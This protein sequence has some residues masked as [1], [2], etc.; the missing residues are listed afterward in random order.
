MIY[1]MLQTQAEATSPPVWTDGNLWA[2]AE[3]NVIPIV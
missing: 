2:V 1:A 3:L